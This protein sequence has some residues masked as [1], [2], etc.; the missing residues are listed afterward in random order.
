MLWVYHGHVTLVFLWPFWAILGGC[1]SDV[2]CLKCIILFADVTSL[3]NAVMSYVTSQCRT[4]IG[5][6]TFYYKRA[7]NTLV[8]DSCLLFPHLPGST[9]ITRDPRVA[10]V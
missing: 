1:T 10:G 2:A 3:N 6:M 8:G 9:L 5:H 7:A 4:C